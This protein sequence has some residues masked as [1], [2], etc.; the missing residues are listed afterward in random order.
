MPLASVYALG[1]ASVTA[2]SPVVTGSG[3][4]WNGAALREGDMFW[5]AGLSV[6]VLAGVSNTELTLAHPW[7]G[8]TRVGASYEIHYTN[9]SQRGMAT[10]LAVLADLNNTGLNPLK[11]ITPAAN[12]LAY[13]TGAGTAAL[14]NLT[15]K[16]RALL[17]RGNNAQIQTEIGLVPQASR[18]DAAAGRLL[19]VGAFGLGSSSGQD[20]PDIDLVTMPTLIGSVAPATVSGT[21]PSLTGVKDGLLN[22]K[23]SANISAQ[24]YFSTHTS[25]PIYYRRSTGASSWTAWTQIVTA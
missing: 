9:D 2:G 23:I 18:Y 1:S 16:A 11:N 24:V 25:S 17:G 3:T 15:A 22:I 10:A 14:T 6:R 13:Y 12:R 8:A 20:V 19:T 21:L 4:N 7:P 5:A